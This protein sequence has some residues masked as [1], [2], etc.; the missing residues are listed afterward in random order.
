MRH[1]VH[2]TRHTPIKAC[3]VWCFDPRFRGTLK[4]FL[5]FL[6]LKEREVDP[7]DLAGGAK[8]AALDKQKHWKN[9][10]INQIQSS[11]RLHHAKRVIL[12]THSDCGGY[13]GLKAF[14][15]DK[16]KELK[17]HA[18]DLKMAA[19]TIKKSLPKNVRIETVFVDFD[20]VW[21]I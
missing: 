6:G 15:H 2:P 19:R 20:G 9:F 16:E 3:V 5:S 21:K 11:V 14:Q 10:L 13:G 12:M 7:V 1:S 4:K 18:R 8:W 17:K